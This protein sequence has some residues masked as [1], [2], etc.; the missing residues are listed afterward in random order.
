MDM[1]LRDV[2]VGWLRKKGWWRVWFEAYGPGDYRG[3]V[4]EWRIEV[5]AVGGCGRL[6]C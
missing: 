2:G 5:S 6:M 4:D 1:L 3:L